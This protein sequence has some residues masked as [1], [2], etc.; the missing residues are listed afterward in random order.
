MDLGIGDTLRQARRRIGCSLSDAAADTRVRETY[1][2]ALEQEE[3]AGLGGDVYVK[4]FIA[5]YARYLEL[6]PEPLLVRYREAASAAEEPRPAPS[7]DPSA[8]GGRGHPPRGDRDPRRRSSGAAVLLVMLV[9]VMLALVV[10][11]LRGGGDQAMAL[12]AH[13]AMG[14]R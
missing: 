11:S 14:S 7:R 2:A 8:G 3:F 4:G 9:I 6:D 10:L 5:S 12:T 13:L 1:L